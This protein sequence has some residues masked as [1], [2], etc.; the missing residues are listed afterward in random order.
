MFLQKSND[1]KEGIRPVLKAASPQL[2]DCLKE[3]LASAVKF[4][5]RAHGYHW[6][7]KGADFAQYHE[8]F[9][10]IY[11]DVYESID[12]F[13]EN[14]LKLGVAAPYKLMDFQMLSKL[15]DTNVSNVPNA[16]ATDLMDANRQLIDC[17][18]RC[19]TAANNANEQGI[20]NFIA[21]RIDMHK[22]WDWQLRSSAGM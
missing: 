4:Y 3:C 13:A 1:P 12:P 18:D 2:V 16:M 6:N 22:K 11:E 5:F 20:A 14:I 17:L 21:E 15:V 10:E 8:L 19:F 9:G 7:V